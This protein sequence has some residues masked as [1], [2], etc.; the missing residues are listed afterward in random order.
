MILM[1][2]LER[3]LMPNST[4]C[5][6]AYPTPPQ[7]RAPEH[8]K[9]SR[10]RS[11]EQSLQAGSINDI[12]PSDVRFVLRRNRPRGKESRMKQSSL[13][14]VEHS[15]PSSSSTP[16]ETRTNQEIIAAQ[17]AQFRANQQKAILSASGN[18]HQG[19][20]IRL[21]NDRGVIRSSNGGGSLRYSYLA[22]TGETVDISDIVQEEVGRAGEPTDQDL[23][24]NAHEERIMSVMERV[25]ASSAAKPSSTLPV[26]NSKLEPF[27]VPK[28]Y[29]LST[30][31]TLV[32]G[33]RQTN[34]SPPVSHAPWWTFEPQVFDTST[35]DPDTQRLY[36]QLLKTE[37]VCLS[38]DCCANLIFVFRL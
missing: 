15:D 25:T 18:Q 24:A 11:M 31:V 5:I 35:F 17:R 29:G 19:T 8:I 37:Q 28:D 6:D 32:Y 26:E 34:P 33:V 21:S 36:E 10:R 12:S 23:L 3:L 16:P 22:P 27:V 38:L 20:D 9:E 1:W 30:L 7:F 2:H 4:K 13:E 14:E